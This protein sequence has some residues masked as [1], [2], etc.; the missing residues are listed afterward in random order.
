MHIKNKTTNEFQ[1]F[2]LNEIIETQ[3]ESKDMYK[4]L[5]TFGELPG[6]VIDDFSK[7]ISL[8]QIIKS[9]DLAGV[10]TGAG[11]MGLKSRYIDVETIVHEL[12]H[13][14]DELQEYEKDFTGGTFKPDGKYRNLHGNIK[15]QTD[16]G[17]FNDLYEMLRDRYEANGNKSFYMKKYSSVQKYFTKDSLEGFAEFYAYYMLGEEYRSKKIIDDHFDEIKSAGISIIKNT[18]SSQQERRNAEHFYSLPTLER[19][20]NIIEDSNRGYK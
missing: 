16:N 11:S 2:D 12:G 18:K 20:Q 4:L 7:E 17:E 14:I 3:P 9:K 1:R 10:Y 6:E 5:K 13:A 8:L 19:I 15:Y